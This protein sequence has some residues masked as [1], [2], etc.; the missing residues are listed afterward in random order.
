MYVRFLYENL[1]LYVTVIKLIFDQINYK[2][3]FFVF[4][5]YEFP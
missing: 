5:L 1:A 4:S 2:R 3:F